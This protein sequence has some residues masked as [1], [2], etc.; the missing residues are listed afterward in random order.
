MEP[1][2][3]RKGKRPLDRGD[4][5]AKKHRKSRRQVEELEKA[6]SGLQNPFLSGF[7][8]L[9]LLHFVPSYS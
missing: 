5:P 2:E 9:L 7:Y 8:L 1:G 4:M 3:E 6:Y